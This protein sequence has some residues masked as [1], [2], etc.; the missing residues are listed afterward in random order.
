MWLQQEEYAAGLHLFEDLPQHIKE[1]V[2]WWQNK[3]VMDQLGLFKVTLLLPGQVAFH[4]T[5]LS[6]PQEREGDQDPRASG[7]SDALSDH[8]V[9]DRSASDLGL[10]ATVSS[11]LSVAKGQFCVAIQR[12]AGLSQVDLLYKSALAPSY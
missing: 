12:L 3:S 1:Q 11:P 6:V 8:S 9:L 7:W 5:L 10:I 4:I 2:S